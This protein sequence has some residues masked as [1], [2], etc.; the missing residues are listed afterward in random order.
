MTGPHIRMNPAALKAARREVR[1]QQNAINRRIK[2][3]GI[4]REWAAAHIR[5]SKRLRWTRAGAS[6]GRSLGGT[7]G[8]SCAFKGPRQ[9]SAGRDGGQSGYLTEGTEEQSA[10]RQSI[11]TGRSCWDSLHQDMSARAAMLMP[12]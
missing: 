12:C 5:R 8:P 9:P 4:V 7:L 2:T 10:Q 6:A 3:L 11:W 1:S